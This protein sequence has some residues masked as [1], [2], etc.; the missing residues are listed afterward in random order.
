MQKYG[1]SPAS[2]NVTE[3]VLPAINKLLSNFPSGPSAG[4]PLVTV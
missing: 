2:S 3:N 1:Y 4:V